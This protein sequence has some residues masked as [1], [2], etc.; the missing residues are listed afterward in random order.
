[1]VCLYKGWYR[2]LEHFEL[3]SSQKWFPRKMSNSP[4]SG[5][6][7]CCIVLHLQLCHAHPNYLDS[8]SWR[9]AMM[10]SRLLIHSLLLLTT[11]MLL[12]NQM[13]RRYNHMIWT[14][15]MPLWPP[16]KFREVKECKRQVIV[17][18]YWISWAPAWSREC[19]LSP[20]LSDAC[21][22]RCSVRC[23]AYLSTGKG[24]IQ[25]IE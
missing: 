5:V 24:S 3:S 19:V 13:W 25:V 18:L 14:T 11:I 8:P 22:C 21:M 16:T 20:D 9:W 1:M 6:T 2:A 23:T 17:P 12:Q 10:M 7:K 15:L 4:A